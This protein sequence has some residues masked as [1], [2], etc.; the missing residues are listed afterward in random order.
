[1]YLESIFASSEDIRKQLPQE[2]ITF[3]D[4]NDNWR[5]N[6][7]F[8]FITRGILKC[9]DVT[10]VK[11]TKI[12]LKKSSNVVKAMLQILKQLDQ[13]QKSLEDYLELKRS[14]FPRFYFL[15]NEELLEILAQGKNPYA[16]Q[17]H[18]KKCFD[19]IK[20]L[21]MPERVEG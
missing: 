2:A 18:I 14:K 4:A 12:Q 19:G 5:R 11:S 6:M 7:E 8:M 20:E 9:L 17:P 3:D 16:V 15:S 21:E 1:M 10:E 13:I